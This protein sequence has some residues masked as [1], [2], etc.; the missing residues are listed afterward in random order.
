MPRFEVGDIVRL[1]SDLS[2]GV[3]WLYRQ[4]AGDVGMVTQVQDNQYSI[5]WKNEHHDAWFDDEDLEL[6]RKFTWE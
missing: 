2:D 1:R 5:F 3:A 4:Y 6:V